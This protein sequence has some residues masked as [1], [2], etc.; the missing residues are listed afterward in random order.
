MPR[1]AT[2][3]RV[4]LAS[5][6][7]VS[8]ERAIV[9]QVCDDLNK[10]IGRRD[11]MVIEVVMWETHGVPAAGRPQQ[12]VFDSIESDIDV[13]VAIFWRRFGGRVRS[14]NHASRNCFGRAGHIFIL[15]SAARAWRRM[16]TGSSLYSP[17]TSVTQ[18]APGSGSNLRSSF[19]TSPA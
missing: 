14:C 17:R 7:D 3:I 10:G 5:P 16:P 4:F 12:V 15:H 19:L 11:D 8:A 18:S 1:N 9:S 6:S 13:F 2:K